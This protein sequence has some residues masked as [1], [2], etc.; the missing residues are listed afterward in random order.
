ML[1]IRG[2]QMKEFEALQRQSFGQT[3]LDFIRQSYPQLC[4]NFGDDA[5]RD[6][7]AQ[8]LRKAREHNITSQADILRYINV[9]F[10]LGCDFETDPD[11][12]WAHDIMS[13]PRL[14]PE[15]KIDQLTARTLEY[16][17]SLESS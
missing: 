5:L 4:A 3:T 2:A 1:I 14:R 12:R 9:M 10:T 13:H 16:L 8:S 11:Y 6:M 17:K 15:S 7:V